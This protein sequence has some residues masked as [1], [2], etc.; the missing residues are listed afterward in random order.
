M[1]IDFF[2]NTFNPTGQGTMFGQQNDT[3][4][5][6]YD[7]LVKQ[8][9]L[10]EDGELNL[11]LDLGNKEDAPKLI[12]SIFKYNNIEPKENAITEMMDNP[13]FIMGLSLMNQAAT[14][15]N[16]GAALMPAA[17]TT[18]GFI[19]NQ[20]LRKQNKKLMRMKE[21]D[22]VRAI[23]KDMSDLA[24]AESSRALTGAQTEQVKS[25]TLL[26]KLRAPLLENQ[27]IEGRQKIKLNE[28][29]IEEKQDERI[30][31][32]AA[33]NSIEANETLS[34]SQKIYYLQNPLT[35]GTI[36]ESITFTANQTTDSLV[37]KVVGSKFMEDLVEKVPGV[38]STE[39]QAARQDALDDISRKATELATIAFNNG[40]RKTRD[41][42]KADV[43]SAYNEMIESG[44]INERG[45]FRSLFGGR[46]WGG[47]V[48]VNNALGGT[49]EA[50][51]PIIVGEE[52]PEVFIPQ[53]NGAIVSNSNTQ[54][55][56]NWEDAIIDN[57]EM[58]MKIKQ[59][60]GTAEAK[61]AL[62]KFR[63][64]LYI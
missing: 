6:F 53:Q 28:I 54:G 55:G 32:L 57:S 27:A 58:L 31:T 50:D 43:D 64:D 60:S 33:Y 2:K 49:V 21:T 52:G 45:W 36:D 23:S 29:T 59:T 22:Q 34:E 4:N 41:V 11:S 51:Q 46:L 44:K 61:K 26:D 18:Q 13:G 14:G 15:K 9:G 17:T 56:Y 63:P 30:Y 48:P 62:K 3:Q 8:Y 7:S 47:G 5:S 35:Y 16:L 12:E 25:N 10:T 37:S 24:T 1:A 19:A 20:D 40:E 39:K 42:T 38:D